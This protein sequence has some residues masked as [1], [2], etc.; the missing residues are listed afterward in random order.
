MLFC[1]SP[2]ACPEF[3]RRACP[4]CP[5]LSRREF[6]R[7]V[8]PLQQNCE[9]RIDFT[10]LSLNVHQGEI[11]KLLSVTVCNIPFGGTPYR[12]DCR[13]GKVVVTPEK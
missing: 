8:H 7:R 1:Y 6:H 12:I 5:E 3:Y 9:F 11:S 13:E 10:I 2:T 4:A